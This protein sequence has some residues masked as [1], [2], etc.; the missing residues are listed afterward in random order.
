MRR[1]RHAHNVVIAVHLTYF[2]IRT[3]PSAR[4]APTAWASGESVTL[5]SESSQPVTT[6]GSITHTI[7]VAIQPCRTCHVRSAND[8]RIAP[9]CSR[10]RHKFA[11]LALP[12]P[13][14]SRRPPGSGRSSS[15]LRSQSTRKKPGRGRLARYVLCPVKGG[16]RD[17]RKTVRDPVPRAVAV[18]ARHRPPSLR[19]D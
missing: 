16:N 13:A 4:Y 15:S 18:H 8:A 1:R 3:R 5:N 2:L 12:A 10:L 6:R 17:P 11:Q 7:T 9:R 19:N 14:R